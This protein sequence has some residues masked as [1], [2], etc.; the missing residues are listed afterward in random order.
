MRL[1]HS[2]KGSAFLDVDDLMNLDNIGF[3]VRSS[4]DNLLVLLTAEILGRFWCAV[5]IATAYS[6]NVNTMV[7]HVSGDVKKNIADDVSTMW[8]KDEFAL[9]LEV[10]VRCED[11]E[12][13]Y[14]ALVALH[15]FSIP[16]DA[17][18]DV[19][20]P[21]LEDIITQAKNV[22]VRRSTWAPNP[23]TIIHIVYDTTSL[24][25]C[26][27]GNI[28]GE[29]CLRNRWNVKAL[30]VPG[31]LIDKTAVSLVLISKNLIGNPLAVGYACKLWK[32][33]IP[34]VTAISQEEFWQPSE[35]SFAMLAKGK[36]FNQSEQAIFESVYLG[37]NAEAANAMWNVYCNLAWRVNPEGNHAVM[38]A[39]FKRILEKIE[40]EWAKPRKAGDQE[41][42]VSQGFSEISLSEVEN[43]DM[44]AGREMGGGGSSTSEGSAMVWV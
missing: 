16:L 1:Q 24:T 9:Y 12:V 17:G 42:Q 33:R 29:L 7:M 32:L 41:R 40:T 8:S 14:K 13:A 44:R 4:T 21:T 36:H 5:E 23:E 10:G 3:T 27:V 2:T 6:N 37:S 25:Q 39:Q 38:N 22:D 31:Q 18:D 19:L 34:C 11:I 26:C 30:K 43:K 35:K 20:Q 15:R 28:F